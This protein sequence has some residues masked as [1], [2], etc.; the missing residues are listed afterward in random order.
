[1]HLHIISPEKS[2]I[3]GVRVDVELTVSSDGSVKVADWD[4]IQMI[5]INKRPL[6]VD[7]IESATTAMKNLFEQEKS[8][9]EVDVPFLYEND[10]LA[11]EPIIRN[12]YNVDVGYWS[13]VRNYNLLTATLTHDNV[14]PANAETGNSV[15][16]ITVKFSIDSHD[17]L[18]IKSVKTNNIF[19][20]LK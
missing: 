17:V 10:S 8:K 16:P 14:E 19:I 18:K 5:G 9:L 11:A 7:L 20:K 6:S 12:E 4:I 2:Y 1:M 3:T 13:F 15:N